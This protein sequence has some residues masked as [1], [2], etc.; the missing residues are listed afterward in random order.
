MLAPHNEWEGSHI[1]LSVSESP[2]ELNDLAHSDL[3]QERLGAAS[4]GSRLQ[5]ANLKHSAQQVLDS[6][7]RH[8]DS[9]T[10]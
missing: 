5:R 9:L 6:A 4:A 8:F 7:S 2:P 10:F 3:A 1:K